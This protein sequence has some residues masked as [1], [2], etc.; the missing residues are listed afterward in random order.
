MNKSIHKT[1][2]IVVSA[3][4]YYIIY[5]NVVWKMVFSPQNILIN[6]LAQVTTVMPSGVS[7]QRQDVK[8]LKWH[9]LELIL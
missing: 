2:S 6:A 7:A 1:I 4:N 5:S 9:S 8:W 3:F